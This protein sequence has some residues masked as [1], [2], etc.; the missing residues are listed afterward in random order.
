MKKWNTYYRIGV[1][2]F[3]LNLVLILVLPFVVDPYFA[4]AFSSFFPIWI[5]LLVVGWRKEHPRQ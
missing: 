2:G 3:I 1:A 5:I 4:S